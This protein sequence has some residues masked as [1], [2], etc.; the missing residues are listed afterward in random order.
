MTQGRRLESRTAA[1]TV[2]AVAFVAVSVV[3]AAVVA[4]AVVVVAVAAVAAQI[5][6]SCFKIK[7]CFRL[8]GTPIFEHFCED[9]MYSEST[10]CFYMDQVL[11]VIKLF[12]VLI[13]KCL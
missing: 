12:T 6:I 2:T 3:A 8:A 9:M 7:L 10:V 11:N 4:V 1:G 5:L 13:Y